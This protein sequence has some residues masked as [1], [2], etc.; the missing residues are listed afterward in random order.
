VKPPDSQSPAGEARDDLFRE[1]A[2]FSHSTPPGAPRTGGDNLR[3]R[4]EDL[5]ECAVAA[6]WP[7][8]KSRVKHALKSEPGDAPR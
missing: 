4:R 5:A 8:G 2:E 1:D 3:I 6:D 7:S